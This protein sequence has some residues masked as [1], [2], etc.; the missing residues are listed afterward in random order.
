MSLSQGMRI[1]STGMSAERFRMDIIS[2]NI[3]GA[4]TVRTPQ[5]DAYRRQ[6]VIF[7]SDGEGVKISGVQ[8]DM[9]PLRP[10][11]EPGNPSA[12]KDGFVYYSNVKPVQEMVDMIG[13]S[14]AYEA[15]INAFNSARGMIRSALN[16]G[17]V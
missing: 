13:A 4:N 2:T 17:K 9:S 7:I 15:N 8:K 11:Y 6:N 12:D 10:V 5:Q 1:S 14:R 3:A 16:I